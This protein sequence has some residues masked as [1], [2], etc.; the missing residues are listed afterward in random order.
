MTSFLK[1]SFGCALIAGLI[2]AAPGAIA[3]GGGTVEIDSPR[4]K[5][6]TAFQHRDYKGASMTAYA[7]K[8]WKYVGGSWNDQISS[9]SISSGCHVKVWQNKN[10]SGESRTF[11]GNVR[12][13][14]DLWNDQTSSWMC[15][16][17]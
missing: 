17:N 6:C 16:C 4:G 2:I 7:N 13:V 14:G 12:F 9:F 8:G 3:A 10:Y 15:Y 1:T 5:R 11:S